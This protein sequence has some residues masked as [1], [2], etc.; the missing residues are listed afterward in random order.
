[1]ASRRLLSELYGYCLGELSLALSSETI[2]RP[3]SSVSLSYL[4][5]GMMSE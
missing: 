3:M 4:G 5:Q 2:A 1:M